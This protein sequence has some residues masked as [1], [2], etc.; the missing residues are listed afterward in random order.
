MCGSIMVPVEHNGQT[1][2]LP[3]IVTAGNGPNLFGRDWVSFLRLDW[4]TIFSIQ[5]TLT[6]QQVLEENTKVFREGPG[7]SRNVKV[8]IY[9]DKDT[10]VVFHQSRQYTIGSEEDG[11]R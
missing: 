2:T 7:E 4:K 11:G 9:V 10:Q 3:L 6:L 8:K 1:A 5:P